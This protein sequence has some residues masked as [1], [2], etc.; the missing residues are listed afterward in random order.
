[1]AAERENRRRLGSVEGSEAQRLRL[2]D[3]H[4]G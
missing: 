2:L 3:R 1:M 4:P